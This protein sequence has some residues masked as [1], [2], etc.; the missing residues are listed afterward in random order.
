MI[1]GAGYWFASLAHT[2]RWPVSLSTVRI[3]DFASGAAVCVLHGHQNR[4]FRVQFDYFKIISSSQVCLYRAVPVL[5]AC[6]PRV[7]WGE[8]DDTIIVWD[9]SAPSRPALASATSI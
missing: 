8:Q 5:T 1:S 7:I 6:L 4:V 2:V 3:W 9:F